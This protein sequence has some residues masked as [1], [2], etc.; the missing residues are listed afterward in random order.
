MKQMNN[1]FCSSI[2]AILLLSACGTAP[3]NDA[4]LSGQST[5][6]DMGEKLPRDEISSVLASGFYSI[7]E[8]ALTPVD[9]RSLGLEGLRGARHH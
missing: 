1:A 3:S 6:V 7:S 2:M 4:H 5:F 9:V 8:R